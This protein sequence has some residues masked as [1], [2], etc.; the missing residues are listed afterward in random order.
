MTDRPILFKTDMVKAILEGRKTQTRRVLKPQPTNK[1]QKGAMDPHWYDQDFVCIAHTGKY[2]KCPYGDLGD[3]LWVRESWCLSQPYDPETYYFQ[4]KADR[5][6][7][8]EPASEKYDYATP[9]IWKP[10]IHMPKEAC[11]LWLNITNI[12]VERLQNITAE[13][14]IAEGIGSWTDDRLKSNPVRYQVYTNEDPEA[15]YTSDPRDS[16]ESLWDSINGKGSRNKSGKGDD[17]DLSWAANPWVW[18]VDFEK[19]TQP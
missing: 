15:L 12:R 2:I 17:L 4:Y 19:T 5:R 9:Y 6:N 8:Y 16:F 7:S 18:V 14:A 1:L 11:R 3:L 13:D 10:S